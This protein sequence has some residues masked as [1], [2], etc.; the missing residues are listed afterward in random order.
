MEKEFPFINVSGNSFEMGYQHGRQAAPLI[1]KYIAWIERFTGKPRVELAAA[2]MRFL[3][4][5][6]KLNRAYVDE[7]MGLAEGAQ[8][9][10]SEAVLCQVRG[11]AA[12]MIDRGCTAFALRKSAT[13]DG[14]TLAGQNQDLEPDYADVAIV[15]AVKPSDGRPRAVMLTFAGQLGY[16]GMN[17]HGV[18]NFANALY[19]FEWRVG[20]PHYPLKRTIL[21]QQDVRHCVDLLNRN[22]TCSAANVMLCDGSGNIASVEVRPEGIAIYPDTHPDVRL[23][24]NHYVT[25]DFARYENG[26]L[27]DS[28][29]RLDRMRKLIRESFGKLSV[30]RLKA[31]LADHDGG[32]AAIC[33][34]G[35]VGMHSISGYIA[36]PRSGLFHVRRGHGCDGHW[37]SYKV[38]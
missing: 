7:V 29:P 15:L 14:R 16:A 4:M 34:H 25:K 37:K 27:P 19:N 8:I 23:H 22:R 18:A 28:C 31:I 12:R 13:A 9:T 6:Q 5:I 1:Q 33:R 26:A 21:E 36:D 17:Q 3:P 38:S 11:E 32:S 30:E 2:A 35:A 20:L 10:L 24:T